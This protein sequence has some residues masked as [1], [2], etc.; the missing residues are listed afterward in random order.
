VLTSLCLSGQSKL[1]IKSDNDIP[2]LTYDN[3]FQIPL[4]LN[5]D[6]F[7]DI[8]N[9]NPC[10]FVLDLPFFNNTI[11]TVELSA[12]NAYTDDFQLL[13]NTANGLIYDNYKPDIKSYK[14]KGADGV[15]GSISFMKN[16][17]IGVIKKNGQVY[18]IKSINENLYVLFDVN[19]STAQS[20]FTCKTNTDN[21]EFQNSS[22]SSS[23]GGGCLEMGIEIDY[24]TYNQFN[25]NCFDAAEWALALLAGVNEIYDSELSS[26][27]D[28]PISLEARYIN[29][30]EIE[31]IY[32]PLTDCGEM[33][34]AMPTYWNNPP[35]SDI[36]AQTDLVHLFSR[37]NANGG[38]AYVGALCG[39]LS[40][41][42]WGFGV[43]TGLNTTL[44]Y[45]YPDNTPYSYNLSYLG[46]EIGHNFGSPHTHNCGWD[47]DMSLSFPGGAIDGCA[48]VEGGCDTPADIPNELWQQSLGTIMSYCDLGSVGISLEFHQIVEN[49]ALI[50]GV[51]S[52]NC[53]TTCDD[54]ET[55][56]GN[57]IYG[58]TDS[59]A[60]NYNP[61][62]NINDN[63]CEYIYG[64]MSPNADNYNPN[65]SMDDG[66]CIC[67]G[68][69]TLFL[70]TDYYSNEV[71]WELLTI[72]NGSTIE[73]VEIGDYFQ[74][75]ITVNQ[76]YCLAEGCYEFN[77]YDSWGDGLSSDN[78]A[79]NEPN[80]YILSLDGDYLVQMDN[81]NY[82]QESLNEFCV[83][84]CEADLDEDNICDEDEIF[85]CTNENYFEYNSIATEDDGSC[86]TLIIEGCTDSFACN[87]DE[88]NNLEDGSCE[89]PSSNFDC[90]G[91]CLSDIN[92]DEICDLFGCMNPDACNYNMTANIDDESC[93][94]PEINF[95]C[96]GNCLINIDCAGDC[97][98]SA[99]VDECGICNGDN[100][101][102]LGCTDILACNY[103]NDAIIEDNSCDY[104]VTNFDC[105]GN[106]L[107]NI[108][109][110]GECGGLAIL[111][112]CGECDGDGPEN[113]FDCNG[114]CLSDM[115]LDGICDQI[116]NCI[117]EY[118]PSQ[119]DNDNDGYG[120]ECSC[121][122]VNI[123]GDIVVESGSYQIYTLS[124]N[125][126]NTA[127]WSITGGNIVWN[128]ANEPSIGVQWLN[129]G[130]GTISFMQFY[131]ENETCVIE[132]NVSII[133]SSI[134]L[135]ENIFNFK[136]ISS[137]KD[138]LGRDVNKKTTNQYIFYFYE[139][140]SVDKIY[141]I[142]K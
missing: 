64:C 57:S 62:A 63:S 71:G 79:G 48:D 5:L 83:I 20:N 134:N 132:F 125:I 46:H 16:Y 109:C 58:C 119:I 8:K 35:F 26:Q 67:S 117:E 97:G 76:T 107:V 141:Q 138:V 25:Q 115:D 131:G 39:G 56:C 1:F 68:E 121:Q 142:N 22:Q 100:T 66:S 31:D 113:F 69:I 106:C 60:E 45:D 11:L 90:E 34:D 137:V 19:K 59:I 23:G 118:N 74:G 24:Y 40:N 89:Y 72:D 61:N 140:G 86:L 33:L 32:E 88:L 17:L 112:E 30:W 6:Y 129:P 80:F 136:K 21:F 111:D 7:D 52:A 102:C 116:D 82:G 98:G 27:L 96:D 135:L 55:S 29:V 41:A 38:I 94:F 99:I 95:D 93:Q 70:E 10:D 9:V 104:P 114:N 101:I 49:Q 75:G 44:T 3:E 91:N 130:E 47:A 18:E 105:D 103:D 36:Y 12:F 51:N 124:S 42:N 128:S 81:L 110:L 92:N 37:K 54:I 43:T 78:T 53:I 85:G 65:A 15:S 120:D 139:D 84:I 14:I 127:S 108:D 87:Y 4:S 13:R 123:I 2:L 126:D 77:I 73:N 133:P 28:S 122:Y 50:P